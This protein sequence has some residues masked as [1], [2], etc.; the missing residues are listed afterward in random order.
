LGFEPGYSCDDISAIIRQVFNLAWSWDLPLVFGAADIA[1]AFDAMV[2]ASMQSALLGRGAHPNLVRAVMREVSH[3][4]CTIQ[5]AG[6]GTSDDFPLERGGKQ[7]GVETPEI[8][9][10][11]M[12]TI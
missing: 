1:T 2:H 8:F 12:D 7:G 11:M 9:N 5:I 10:S 4:L 3:M 6:A